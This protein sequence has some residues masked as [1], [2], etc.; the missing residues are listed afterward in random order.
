MN[1]NNNKGIKCEDC[2][3]KISELTYAWVKRIFPD[4][5]SALRI[6]YSNPAYSH[7]FFKDYYLL[8]LSKY[9]LDTVAGILNMLDLSLN[10]LP[11]PRI[12]L[13]LEIVALFNYTLS[14]PDFHHSFVS[15][16]KRGICHSNNDKTSYI[17]FNP[18]STIN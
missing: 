2:F 6:S 12:K 1:Q 16:I 13:Y 17:F 9:C 10:I 7:T 18:S 11:Y 14:S 4:K 3:L 15:R 8:M 5:N